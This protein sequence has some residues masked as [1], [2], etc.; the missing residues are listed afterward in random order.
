[1][2]RLAFWLAVVYFIVGL[3][4]P[5]LATV[6]LTASP[7]A[8][9]TAPVVATT[10]Q[11]KPEGCNI[12]MGSKLANEH[13]VGPITNLQEERFEF[14]AKNECTVNYD[15][16]VDG[17]SHHVD[18]TETSLEQMNSVCYY[19]RE[20]GRKDLLLSLGGKF[21]SHANIDCHYRETIG[22]TTD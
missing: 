17:E 7:D 20:R 6:D 14:G 8:E 1:M 21:N 13:V 15:I 18:Q 9:Q 3:F 5:E 19:A 16:V 2:I 11:N 22:K 4:H 10:I 12:D